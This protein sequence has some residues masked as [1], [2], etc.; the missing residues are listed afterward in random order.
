MTIVDAIYKTLVE[1][2][3]MYDLLAKT[4]WD[5]PAIYDKFRPP[6]DSDEIQYPYMTYQVHME[7]ISPWPMNLYTMEIDIWD[8]TDGNDQT[9]V[10]AIRER[11]KQLLD[12]QEIKDDKGVPSTVRNIIDIDLPDLAGIV[13]RKMTFITKAIDF[14]LLTI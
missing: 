8:A 2:T 10:L 12:R 14:E 7:S 4:E 11:V 1:D 13:H 3:E 5:I 9:T 6:E